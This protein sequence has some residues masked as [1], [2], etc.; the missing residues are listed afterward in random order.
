MR[1]LTKRVL[2]IGAAAIAVGLYSTPAQAHFTYSSYSG[3]QGQVNGSHDYLTVCD[4][5][6]D[7][8]GVRIEYR[9]SRGGSDHVGDA[10]GS[11]SGCGSEYTYDGGVVTQWRMCEATSCEGWRTNL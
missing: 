5:Q 8:R 11:A 1:T 10:N 6:A 2:T 9:T 3:N 7:N 4:L